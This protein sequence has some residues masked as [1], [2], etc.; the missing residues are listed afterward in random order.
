VISTRTRPEIVCAVFPEIN[1]WHSLHSV[2]SNCGID[3]GGP[4]PSRHDPRRIDEPSRQVQSVADL[5]R[6]DEDRAPTIDH[7][8]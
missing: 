1:V 6:S 7:R 3:A 2:R 4:A 8:Q 5:P